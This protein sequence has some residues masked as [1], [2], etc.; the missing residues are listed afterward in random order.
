MTT[1]C[2][3][4][5]ACQ[6]KATST[7]APVQSSLHCWCQSCSP[8]PAV[9][10]MGKAPCVTAAPSS[11]PSRRH[12]RSGSNSSAEAPWQTDSVRRPPQRTPEAQLVQVGMALPAGL[13]TTV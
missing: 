11:A 5:Q 10:Q 1:Q 7:L 4:N 13:A 2:T 12:V 8:A 3:Y 6:M 9:S